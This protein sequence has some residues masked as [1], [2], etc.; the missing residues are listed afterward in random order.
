MSEYSKY[1]RRLQRDK[2]DDCYIKIFK[3]FHLFNSLF[4]IARKSWKLDASTR[5]V[6]HI[7]EQED[8]KQE[9]IYIN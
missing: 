2:S 4:A 1:I 5:D 6:F 3:N 8:I 9:L 7:E